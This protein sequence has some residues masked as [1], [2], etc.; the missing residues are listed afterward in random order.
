MCRAEMCHAHRQE[1][2]RWWPPQFPE[3]TKRS[4]VAH[5]VPGRGM[6]ARTRPDKP[7]KP[8]IRPAQTCACLFSSP[9]SLAS[10]HPLASP[11]RQLLPMWLTTMSPRPRTNAIRAREPSARPIR[12]AAENGNKDGTKEGVCSCAHSTC[13]RYNLECLN[14]PHKTSDAKAARPDTERTSTVDHDSDWP[15][16]RGDPALPSCTSSAQEDT[17]GQGQHRT[18]SESV[19]LSLIASLWQVTA[20]LMLARGCQ[21]IA[22]TGRHKHESWRGPPFVGR[23][24]VRLQG[25]GTRQLGCWRA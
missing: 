25:G 17:A 14:L 20:R 6:A 9:A 15:R 23:A 3:T 19:R 24:S 2:R 18:G 13:G 10:Q 21:R 7:G 12:R 8:A 4:S 5:L 1:R 11:R 22:L 16:A